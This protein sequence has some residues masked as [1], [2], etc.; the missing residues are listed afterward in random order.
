MVSGKD[1]KRIQRSGNSGLSSKGAGQCEEETLK[2]IFEPETADFVMKFL[3]LL[4]DK[5]RETAI[6]SHHTGICKTSANEARNIAEA[7][8]T[9]ALPDSRTA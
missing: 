1:H 7:E 6:A 5:R 8:V 3:L 9:T 4:V 2:K